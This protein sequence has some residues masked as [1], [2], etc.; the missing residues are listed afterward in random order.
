MQMKI[1]GYAPGYGDPSITSVD[2]GY[3]Q[4]MAD[5]NVSLGGTLEL[6]LINGF[7]PGIGS[8]FFLIDN[9]GG[10]VIDGTFDDLP[11]DAT[12]SIDGQQFEI[13]YMGDQTANGGAGSYSGGNDVVLQVVAVPEPSTLCI[14]GVGSGVLF[15]VFRRRRLGYYHQKAA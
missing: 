11:Q 2:D 5:G 13:G 4:L 12:L 1:G 8:L 7:K 14:W 10:N 9:Q 15:A 3:D 6:Q